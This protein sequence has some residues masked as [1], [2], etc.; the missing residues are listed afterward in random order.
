MV[1]DANSASAGAARRTDMRK[2]IRILCI[3]SYLLL[4]TGNAQS[5]EDV[6]DCDDMAQIQ[7]RIDEDA[8]AIRAYTDKY[9]STSDITLNTS[10]NHDALQASVQAQ[11]SDVQTTLAQFLTTASPANTSR[12]NGPPPQCMSEYTEPNLTHCMRAALGVH[13]WVHETAC[14]K[15]EWP[16]LLL[17]DFI[18]EEIDA[19]TAERNFL[20][21]ERKRLL[22][23]CP[24][25]ALRF[26]HTG[27]WNVQQP[28]IQGSPSIQASAES[29]VQGLTSN[30]I[31]V[32]LKIEA[33]GRVSGQAQTE[34]KGNSAAS[35][36]IPG[37]GVETAHA[38]Q[39]AP[40][41]I[42]VDG[43]LAPLPIRSL[44]VDVTA[45]EGQGTIQG[46]FV[47]PGK[48]FPL[49]ATTK[50]GSVTFPFDIPRLETPVEPS[51]I[52]PILLGSPMKWTT[53]SELTV[54]DPWPNTKASNGRGSTVGD[55]LHE[56]GTPF[57][58]Q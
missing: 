9:L 50:G 20:V 6:C 29:K 34:F 11:L 5:A 43:Q 17:R 33:G 39:S 45:R 8:V 14:T 37:A 58:S 40:L 52:P 21:S 1:N 30:D 10:G 51:S 22:C 53:T 35:E 48:T 23:T 4:T 44:H 16:T 27:T 26:S 24:Y 46:Q 42:S 28:S 55:A 38:S 54:A 32:P 41:A 56:I 18:K 57:C 3:A 25:Y 36:V 7:R 49:K 13:E 19:Y 12:N 47:A 31:N 2:A 15:G